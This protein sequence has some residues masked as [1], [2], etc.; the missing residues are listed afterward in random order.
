MAKAQDL[1]GQRFGNLLVTELLGTIKGRRH[2]AV[3]CDCGATNIK[4][5]SNLSSGG[6]VVCS[7]HCPL[8]KRT[9]H[10]GARRKNGKRHYTYQV[11]LHWKELNVPVCDEWKD[12]P[13]CFKDVG[14]RPSPNHVLRR[15][16]VRKPHSKD[17]TY[18]RNKLERDTSNHQQS[19]NRMLLDFN[20]HL[21]AATAA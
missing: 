7:R 21:L 9:K 8:N 20:A 17:N 14:K 15:R 3:Q 12:Y 18:W 10:R 2:Y 19:D 13:A 5:G 16:D 1:T 11:W 6:H 4:K